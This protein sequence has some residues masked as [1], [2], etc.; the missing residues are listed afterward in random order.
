[1]ILTVDMLCIMGVGSILALI[2]IMSVV[3]SCLL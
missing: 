1:M 2:F 3:N